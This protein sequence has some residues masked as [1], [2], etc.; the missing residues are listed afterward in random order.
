MDK[1][2][3]IP[4][5]TEACNFNWST[6]SMPSLNIIPKHTFEKFAKCCCVEKFSTGQYFGSVYFNVFTS[7]AA[8]VERKQP[9][10]I[11]KLLLVLTFSAAAVAGRAKNISDYFY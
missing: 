9:K 3:Q 10:G 1:V 2:T 7:L 11:E 5:V 8:T 4:V 6:F